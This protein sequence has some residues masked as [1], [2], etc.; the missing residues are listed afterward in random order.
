MSDTILV[1]I[2]ARTGSTRLPG[3]VL[4]KLGAYSVLQW[5]V[6]RAKAFNFVSQVCLATTKDASDDAIAA[7]A[8]AEQIPCIRHGV[9]L[10]DGRNDVLGRYACAARELKAAHVV[11]ITS[12]CPFVSLQLAAEVWHRYDWKT[13]TA[14]VTP[15]LD[16]FDV[17]IFPAESLF[18]LDKS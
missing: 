13:Y 12:D 5:V 4:M 1:V 8:K 10:S 15:A 3:K 17:E 9:R 2:Q 18:A 11:R 6:R 7:L 16:G 14:N